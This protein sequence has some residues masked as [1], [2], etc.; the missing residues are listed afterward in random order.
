[1]T[2]GKKWAKEYPFCTRKTMTN[3]DVALKVSSSRNAVFIILPLPD[4]HQQLEIREKGKP[5]GSASTRHY[6]IPTNPP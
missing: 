2:Q 1:M 4:V 5:F 3:R 6:D